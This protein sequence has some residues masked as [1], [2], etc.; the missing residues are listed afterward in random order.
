M[1]RFRM[2][3]NSVRAMMFAL[4]CDRNG[5]K[6]TGQKMYGTGAMEV[7]YI[8]TAKQEAEI[9]QGFGRM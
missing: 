7:T 5:I 8:A 9:P 1:E 3:G 4:W 6:V 2:F